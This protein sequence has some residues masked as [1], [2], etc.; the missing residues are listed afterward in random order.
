MQLTAVIFLFL[1]VLS[2]P[3][4]QTEN[5][6]N[7]GNEAKTLHVVQSNQIINSTSVFYNKL[8][9]LFQAFNQNDTERME[10]IYKTLKTNNI[11]KLNELLDANSTNNYTRGFHD[12]VVS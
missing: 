1:I 9:E 10:H 12:Y 8:E 5:I 7:G 11:N 4:F 6:N 3:C 2:I